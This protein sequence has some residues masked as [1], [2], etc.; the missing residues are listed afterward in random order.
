MRACVED[1]VRGRELEPMRAENEILYTL[2]PLRLLRH[3]VRDEQLR[4]RMER[5]VR[6]G[7]V[8]DPQRYDKDRSIRRVADVLLTEWNQV[9]KFKRYYPEPTNTSF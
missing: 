5:L 9:R 7:K 8:F 3:Y 4:A 6:E 2:V 1:L